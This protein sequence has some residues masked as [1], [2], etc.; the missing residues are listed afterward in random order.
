[1]FSRSSWLHLRIPFSYFLLPVF[2]FSLSVSPNIGEGSLLWT[3]FILHF[4]LYPAS[5]GF[6]SYF[7]KDEKSIGGLKNPPPVSRGLY[8]L[9]LFFDIVAIVL[10]VVKISIPFAFMLI[11]YSAVSRAYS[12]PWIRLKKYAYTSWLVA[13]FFQ[14]TFTFVMCYVGVNKF[15]IIQSLKPSVMMPAILTSLMLWGNYPMTQIY[16]HEED[17]KRGD[18]TLSI[19]LG[20]KGTFYFVFS[21]FGLACCGFVMYLHHTYA[22]F[23]SFAFLLALSP[24]LIFFI[25]WFYLVNRNE[26][27]ANYQNTMWLNFISAT[28]LN[29]FFVYL[30]LSTTYILG[31]FTN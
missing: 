11:V 12:H 18:I 22:T 25:V 28:C 10:A 21:M 1:M 8:Y 7:D 19:R 16:Q 3:F 24:V 29:V 27:W 14:G 17:T 2:L 9:S 20:I 26:K 6:N 30:F 4:L 13:G 5:N 23:Y 15:E 31:V